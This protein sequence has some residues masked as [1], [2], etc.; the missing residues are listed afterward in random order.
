MIEEFILL[1]ESGKEK[2]FEILSPQVDPK[3][4]KYLV[5]GFFDEEQKRLVA[6]ALMPVNAEYFWEFNYLLD[7]SHGHSS[8]LFKIKPQ[9]LRPSGMYPPGKPLEDE[10]KEGKYK[11][12]L[13]SFLCEYDFDEWNIM[14]SN[15]FTD[16][17][18]RS[19][20][21]ES[22]LRRSNGNIMDYFFNQ[23]IFTETQKHYDDLN[24]RLKQR[25]PENP[26]FPERKFDMKV[27][28][29]MKPFIGHSH[30]VALIR[31][32]KKREVNQAYTNYIQKAIFDPLTIKLKT[33]YANDYHDIKP[34]SYFQ[35]SLIFPEH[36]KFCLSIYISINKS[37]S[38]QLSFFLYQQ[39]ND[40]VYEWTYFPSSTYKKY[41][42]EPYTLPGIFK[43]ISQLDDQDYLI[44]AECTL[45]DDNFWNN[46]VFKKENEEYV[47]LK[48][49]KFKN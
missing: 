47:Y 5:G 26:K 17:K 20:I 46:Y 43:P 35:D 13:I 25:H 44:K 8:I 30:L 15:C 24:L 9:D 36:K 19:K 49:I 10:I 31:V 42:L 22:Q 11:S 37:Q 29:E 48:E 32:N 41:R 6:Y 18:N 7:F 33:F 38:R 21:L 12:N 34:F 28:T 3:I 45:D 40:K 39:E 23:S 1:L 14:R 2:A 16:I 27:P 4:L